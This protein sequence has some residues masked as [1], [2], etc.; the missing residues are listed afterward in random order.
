MIKV[1]CL[2]LLNVINSSNSLAGSVPHTVDLM[3]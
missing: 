1:N 3:L 2:S